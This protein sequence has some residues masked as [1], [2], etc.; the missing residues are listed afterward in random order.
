MTDRARS[1]W[2][3]FET[4]HAVTYFAPEART[5][6]DAV[7]LRGFWMAYAAQRIAPLGA[8][9]PEV[10]EA[11]FFVFH[12][13]RTARALP[14]AWSFSTP[15]DCLRARREGAVAALRRV[16]DEVGAG[17]AVEQ[18]VQEAA[19][20]A[21]RAAAA[22]DTSGRVL[23]AANRALP[24][25][26][27]PWAALWQATTT[28]REHRGDGHVAALVAHGLGPI[29]AQLLKTAS[30][31]APEDWMRDSR[32][33]PQPEWDAAVRGLCERGLLAD[34]GSLTPEGRAL[35]ETVEDATDR[36]A[37]TPWRRLGEDDTDRLAVLL[38]PLAAAVLDTGL[39][40]VPN[41]IGLVPSR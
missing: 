12:A 17:P 5:A 15:A 25:P 14:D 10:A 31:D 3:L 30:G 27:E 36:A 35:R 9:G 21:G 34:G 39:L 29:E 22:T 24:V 13:D 7:G 40:P 2:H 33:W 28:L 32:G 8:V 4:V 19:D 6:A 18:T 38:A 16:A 20:L 26:D 1:M 23:A 37:E 11:A 41:P